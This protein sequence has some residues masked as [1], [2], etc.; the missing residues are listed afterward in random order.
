MFPLLLLAAAFVYLEKGPLTDAFNHLAASIQGGAPPSPAAQA[1]N[2]VSVANANR[3][4]TNIT[5]GYSP[6]AAQ[7]SAANQQ[8][9]DAIGQATRAQAGH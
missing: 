2:P 9:L 7:S 5:F 6:V 8:M 3:V 4:G 1:G